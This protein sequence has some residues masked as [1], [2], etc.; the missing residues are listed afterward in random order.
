MGHGIDLSLKK[1]VNVVG[2]HSMHYMECLDLE[3]GFG[4]F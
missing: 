2:K 4:G 1:G 3:L